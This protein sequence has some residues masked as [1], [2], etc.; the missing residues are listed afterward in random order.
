MIAS[1]LIV[2]S[3]GLAGQTPPLPATPQQSPCAKALAD[4]L[5]DGAASEICSGDEAARLAN[6]A[7]K[8]SGATA[9]STRKPAKKERVEYGAVKVSDDVSLVS[10]LSDSGFTLTVALNF[11]DH[12]V[13]GFA[14]GA[15]EWYPVRGT[16]EVVD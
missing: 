16:F 15:K 11:S 4:A 8:D 1:V 7:L 13:V 2:A 9:S 14:S 12:T 5:A 6:A 10:Y 3:I